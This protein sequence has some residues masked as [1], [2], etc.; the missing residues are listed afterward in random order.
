MENITIKKT[1]S[2][3][4]VYTTHIDVSTK[5]FPE[6]LSE[7]FSFDTMSDDLRYYLENEDGEDLEMDNTNLFVFEKL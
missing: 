1:Q 5:E 7:S 6:L 4:D 2:I 3:T